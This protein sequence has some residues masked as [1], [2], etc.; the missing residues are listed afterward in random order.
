MDLTQTQY[1]IDKGIGTITLHRP[2]R[3]NAFTPVIREELIA[4]F[5]EADMND[6][7]RAVVV[8]GSGNAFCAG[9]DLSGGGSTFDQSA[10]TTINNHRDGGGQVALAIHRCRKPV[11]AAINGHAVGI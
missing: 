4:L 9:A 8:T 6:A 5:A 3:M 2:D 1:E 7:V 10:K 11:I